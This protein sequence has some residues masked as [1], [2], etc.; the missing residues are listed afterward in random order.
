MFPLEVPPGT[1]LESLFTDVLPKAHAQ[2]VPKGGGNERFVAVQEVRG[3]GSYTLDI[4]GD[5]L[6]VTAGE[7]AKPDFWVTVAE[8]TAQLFHDGWMGPKTLAPKSMPKEIVA[9]SDPRVLKRLALVN[10]K[11]ELALVDLGKG[12]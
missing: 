11:A 8:E 5:V 1:T 4:R 10:A 3:L 7:T 2:M 9:I 6:T 12:G